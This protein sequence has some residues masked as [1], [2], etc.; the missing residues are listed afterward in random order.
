[1][2]RRTFVMTIGSP[3]A[4]SLAGCTSPFEGPTDGTDQPPWSPSDPID[5][6]DAVHHLYIENRT[7]TTETAWIRVDR[8]DGA[9][10]INGRYELPD[11]RAI[12]F[13]SIAAWE[14][15]Y[16]LRL[17]VEE[18]DV[19]TLEWRTESCGEAEESPG[20]G[21]SRNAFVRLTPAGEA[22]SERLSLVVDGCDALYGPELPT[23][24]AD[25][26]RLD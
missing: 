4:A 10:L 16:T 21:G 6:P 13:E 12:E 25:A 24:N 3:L 17:A 14:R 18:R 26:F 19:R 5:D 15:T 20:S 1:M 11:E 7:E 8:D 22:A 23:G 2:Q 9:T